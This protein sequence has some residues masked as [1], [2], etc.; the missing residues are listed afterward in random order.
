MCWYG[1]Y[2]SILFALDCRQ[3]GLKLFEHRFETGTSHRGPFLNVIT[4]QTA[5]GPHAQLTEALGK[6]EQ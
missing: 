3:G 4:S 1:F 6:E 2:G 5:L